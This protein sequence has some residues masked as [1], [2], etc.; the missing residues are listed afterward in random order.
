MAVVVMTATAYE[1]IVDELR[2]RGKK[3]KE[4]S[5]RK[6]AKAQCPSQDH[7]QISL[8]VYAKQGRAK[9]VCYAGSNDALDIL[10]ALEMTVADLYDDPHEHG[11][12]YTPDPHVLARIDARRN[13]TALQRVLDDLLDRPDIGTRL[14][15]GVAQIRPELYF[16]E[17]YDLDLSS[18][19]TLV[20]DPC[21]SHVGHLLGGA[22]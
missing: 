10:P 16:A 22:G 7:L 12:V 3:V 13:M 17:K 19:E 9:I 1:R 11:I 2:S 15:L 21:G 18:N 8:G 20:D 14:V 4:S 6:S 5:T